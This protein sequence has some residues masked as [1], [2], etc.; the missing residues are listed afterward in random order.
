MFFLSGTGALVLETVWFSQAGLVVGNS[1]WSA[2][3]VAAAFMAGLGL[4]NAITMALARRGKTPVRAY[5]LVETLAA[6]SGALLV[7]AFP[8]LPALLRP[9]FV[10]LAEDVAA[11]N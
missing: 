4:G 3:L 9:L 5:A 7:A 6:G 1:V 2:S 10:P 8:F 11:L